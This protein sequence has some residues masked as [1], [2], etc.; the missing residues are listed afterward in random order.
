MDF[1]S[2]EKYDDGIYINPNG[3]FYC[4]DDTSDT[5]YRFATYHYMMK[6]EEFLALSDEEREDW[7]NESVKYIYDLTE[8]EY[9]E[10]KRAEM[11]DSQKLPFG[12]LTAHTPVGYYRT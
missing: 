4:S 2:I 10:Q 7:L 3:Y 8:E 12:M 1:Y 5:P 6:L 11:M 9:E